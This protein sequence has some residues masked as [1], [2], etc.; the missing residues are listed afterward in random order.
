MRNYIYVQL[1][2]SPYNYLST[3]QGSWPG[4]VNVEVTVTSRLL[5]PIAKLVKIFVGLYH[6]LA[7]VNQ[8]Q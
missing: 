6:I 7:Q 4:G 2:N 8:L 1:K 5:Q 3:L